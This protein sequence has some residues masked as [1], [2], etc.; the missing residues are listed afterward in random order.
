MA[1][2][3]VEEGLDLRT[4]EEWEEAPSGAACSSSDHRGSSSVDERARVLYDVSKRLTQIF[5]DKKASWK[6][7]HPGQNFYAV[8]SLTR[9]RS[10]G[11]GYGT[12][13]CVG[14]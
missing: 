10:R 12:S 6:E 7:E 14:C 1:T 2:D 8:R 4:E 3:E 5:E 9:G 13:H 11:I